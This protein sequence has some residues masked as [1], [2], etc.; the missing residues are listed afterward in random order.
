[1]MVCL[2]LSRTRHSYLK[3]LCYVF[4]LRMLQGNPIFKVQKGRIFIQVQN[5][6]AIWVIWSSV[7]CFSKLRI[8]D[9]FRPSLYAVRRVLKHN[10]EASRAIVSEKSQTPSFNVHFWA[11][12]KN[13]SRKELIWGKLRNKKIRFNFWNHCKTWPLVVRERPWPVQLSASC[14]HWP[15]H[16]CYLVYEKRE[17]NEGQGDFPRMHW[18][19]HIH[20]THPTSRHWHGG[21]RWHTL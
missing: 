14:L 6:N 11:P 2:L 17:R 12:R 20:N 13:I 19:T 4:I 15:V 1:M 16:E 9:M 21:T 5:S 8:E 3:T 10:K 7:G 18:R